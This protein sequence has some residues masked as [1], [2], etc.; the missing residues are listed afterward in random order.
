MAPR[1]VLLLTFW[2]LAAAI[3][4]TYVAVRQEPVQPGL[5]I[6]AQHDDLQRLRDRPLGSW[7]PY[8]PRPVLSKEMPRTAIAKAPPL[9]SEQPIIKRLEK[10]KQRV[11][12]VPKVERMVPY[13]SEP[14]PVAQAKSRKR[15]QK[16]L[17]GA[18]NEQLVLK[19]T[20]AKVEKPKPTARLYGARKKVIA[21]G[22]KSG[23][24]GRGGPRGLGLFALSGDFGRPTHATRRGK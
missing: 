2:L 15:S 4:V 1:N 24:A 14:S 11:V 16:A 3:C 6:S 7:G 5:S 20:P 8:L 22:P 19:R 10:P 9:G 21:E 23:F 12:E 13:S 18:E 17:L